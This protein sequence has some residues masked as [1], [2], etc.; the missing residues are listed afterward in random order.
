[1]TDNQQKRTSSHLSFSHEVSG[2]FPLPL[3]S[4]LIRMEIFVKLL[5]YNVY[6]IKKKHFLRQYNIQII[7]TWVNSLF[8]TLRLYLFDKD[9]VK[10]H[11][12]LLVGI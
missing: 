12:E 7:S 4:L 6:C 9:G 2:G 10:I 1:M 11:R 3:S 8:E 5:C